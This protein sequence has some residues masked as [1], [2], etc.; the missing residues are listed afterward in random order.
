MLHE[1]LG[2]ENGVRV[3]ALV[4]APE[5]AAN[6]PRNTFLYVNRRSVRDSAVL[7]ALG[8]AYGELLERGRYPR[9]VLEVPGQEVDVNVHPQKLEVRFSRAQEVAAA[10]RHIVGAAIARAPWLVPPGISY[11]G[12]PAPG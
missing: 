7:A 1:A 6:T 11:G 2:E 12:P 3:H 9:A 8:L 5:E 4:A 10:V